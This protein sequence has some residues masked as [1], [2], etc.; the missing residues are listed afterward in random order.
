MT[1]EARP[2]NAL[3][4]AEQAVKLARHATQD[5]RD[6][7]LHFPAAMPSLV[8][9][10][11]RLSQAMG[12]ILANALKFTPEGQSVRIGGYVTEDGGVALFVE[13]EGIGMAEETIAAALEPFRQVDGTL[14]RKFE[15]TGLGLSIARAL[16]ELHDGTLSIRSAVGGGTTVTLTLPPARAL[17]DLRALAS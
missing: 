11:R 6:I 14:A 9:D 5:R 4:I 7:P 10:P 8:V 12:N 2:E 1:G 13:D 3:D 17:R 16:V 15:G